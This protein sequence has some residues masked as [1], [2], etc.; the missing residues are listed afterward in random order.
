LKIS[1]LL[2]F[3]YLSGNDLASSHTVSDCIEN[4]KKPKYSKGLDVS[5]RLSS[6]HPIS[7]NVTVVV[8]VLFEAV[9][10]AASS[11]VRWADGIKRQINVRLIC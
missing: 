1:R 8:T 3:E 10:I 5:I 9:V 2:P 7:L 11:T 6:Y 4:I